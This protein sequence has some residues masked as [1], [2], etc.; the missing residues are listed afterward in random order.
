MR[1][2]KQPLHR[3]YSI[4]MRNMTHSE[5]AVALIERLSKKGV[6]AFSRS[7]LSG[8]VYVYIVGSRQMVR[9]SDHGKHRGWFRYNIRTDLKKGRAFIFRG[10]RVFVF[11][12]NE[13]KQVCFTVARDSKNERVKNASAIIK[14][15]LMRRR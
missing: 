13:I 4:V 12:E 11:T 5:I 1:L 7:S 6:P 14:K 8:S 3:Y 2:T 15:K 9:I 10:Q